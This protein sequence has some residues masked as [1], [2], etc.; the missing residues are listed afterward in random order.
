MVSKNSFRLNSSA[1][2]ALQILLPAGDLLFSRFDFP[3]LQD[4]QAAYAAK[5]F[6]FNGKEPEVSNFSLKIHLQRVRNS[7]PME[8]AAEPW[9]AD[10]GELLNG[11]MQ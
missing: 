10:V 5:A 1:P 9:N 4:L 6:N 8:K 3:V 7:L 2:S 11:K